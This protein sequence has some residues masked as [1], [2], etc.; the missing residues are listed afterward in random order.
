M[1]AFLAG[2]LEIKQPTYI[3]LNIGNIGFEVNIP[4]STFNKLGEIGS[5]VKILTYLH[6]KED[7]LTLYGFAT[8]EEKELFKQIISASGI[9]TKVALSLLSHLSVDEIKQAI[10]KEDIFTLQNV[11]GIGK[12]KAERIILELR[13]KMPKVLKEV[14]V[15]KEENVEVINDAISA[16]VS[17]GYTQLQAKQ[18]VKIVFEEKKC[19]NLENLIKESLK[20]L[21]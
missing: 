10:F 5:K 21:K 20:K 2:K 14:S 7:A 3:V 1:F 11:P 15:S 17:L 13:E 6:V 19:D 12:K 16:L 9:G 8:V 18:V 4:I